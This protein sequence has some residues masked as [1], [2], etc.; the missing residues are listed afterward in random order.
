VHPF[1]HTMQSSRFEL[2]YLIDE[3]CARA[4][5]EFLRCYL[6]P[7]RYAADRPNCEYPVCSLYLDSRDL[8]LYRA[9]LH[10]ERNRFKLRIR[11]YDDRAES[12]AFFE[13]KRRLDKVIVKQ[14]AAVRRS[15]VARLLAGH[16]PTAGDLLD[17]GNGQMGALQRFCDLR[18]S[19]AAD[20][21]VFVRYMREA[22]VSPTDNSLRITFDRDLAGGAFEGDASP[23]S[24]FR[25]SRAPVDRVILEVK[26]TDRFPDW[27]RHM[28]SVF[29][30]TW[31]SVAKY[32]HCVWQFAPPG[33]RLGGFGGH[34]QLEARP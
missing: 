13:I 18:H 33:L 8:A 32:V 22:Y 7:D 20:G 24:V 27:I 9:T 16:L 31:C 14:R 28:V 29:N 23:A 25:W 4:V 3:N 26:F 15:Q 30:L 6:V 21:R 11:Y 1:A 19:V 5:S 2:K 17:D 10:G 34:S 12:P